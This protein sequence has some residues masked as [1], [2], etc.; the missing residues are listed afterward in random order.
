MRTL[1]DNR[2]LKRAASAFVLAWLVTSCTHVWAFA[3]YGN[4]WLRLY[5]ASSSGNASCTLC[6]NGSRLNEW[7]SYGWTIR[8]GL[9]ARLSITNAILAAE[10]VDSDGEGHTNLQEI[11]AN[12]QPG[13]TYGPNNTTHQGI[14]K[15]QTNQPPP[16]GLLGELDPGGGSGNKP[17][18][19][20][21]G[22]P[23]LDDVGQPVP[24][25]GTGSRDADGTI[26][27]YQWSFGDGTVSTG[28]APAHAYAAPGTYDVLL[29]V[30]DDDGL[31]DTA[32]TTAT[33]L[34]ANQPPVAD[35]GGP[36]SGVSGQ[37]VH[38]DG[39]GSYDPDGTIVAYLWDFGD[40]SNAVGA[41]PV[42]TYDAP[43]TYTVTLTVGDDGGQLSEWTTTA[44]IDRSDPG[45]SGDRWTAKVPFLNV[46][47]ALQFEDHDGLLRVEETLP[48]GQV[49]PGI[50]VENG[51]F[52]IW[53][54]VLGSLFYGAVDR[55][56]GT[57]MG[58]V[59]DLFGDEGDTTWFAE[60]F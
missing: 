2:L 30:T 44:E 37:P 33:I 35:P 40:G 15:Q 31:A 28:A 54:D 39:S 51:S 56:A 16:T 10:G 25:D 14:G 23:Y 24:F 22:G 5:P 1:N 20:D 7:N 21:P 18:V 43:G 36:Y 41:A 34:V 29:T 27:A 59:F 49:I 17:P 50:G 13:W 55:D 53:F 11:A 46:E 47:F 8:R 4:L 3:G 57:M 12:A 48:D 32:A 19:S 42:H 60:Q 9:D 26:V 52:I 6:H 45:P 58:I 38:F